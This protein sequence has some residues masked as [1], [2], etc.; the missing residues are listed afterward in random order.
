MLESPTPAATDPTLPPVLLDEPEAP[1]P[2]IVVDVAGPS[3]PSSRPRSHKKRRVPVDPMGGQAAP[4]PPFA[5]GPPEDAKRDASSATQAPNAM[6][7]LMADPEKAGKMLVG[8]VDGLLTML[9]KTRYGSLIEPNSGKPLVE[10]MEVSSK[11]KDDLVDAV[12]LFMKAS[13]MQVSPGL[14]LA[15]AFGAT[16]GGR[17]L[18]LESTRSAMRKAQAQ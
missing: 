9:A 5:A 18:A 10:L 17:A 14:N 7:A 12:V 3:M 16:Y 1:P 2:V 8:V 13:S 4:P 11:E 15:M 6:R